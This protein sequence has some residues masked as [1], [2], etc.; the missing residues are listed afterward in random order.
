MA[1]QAALSESPITLRLPADL[2]ER[3]DALGPA[4]SADAD[5]ALLRATQRRVA[6]RSLASPPSLAERIRVYAR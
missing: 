5:T 1:K 2:L 3:L 4:I 6:E